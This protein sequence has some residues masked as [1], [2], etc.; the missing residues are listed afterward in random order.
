MNVYVESNFVLEVAL[1]QEQC[2]SCLELIDLSEAG[3]IRLVVPAYCLVEPFETLIRHE[4]SRFK[5]RGEV[6]TEL[7][8]IARSTPYAGRVEEFLGLRAFLT[9]IA[10][11]ETTRLDAT[12]S[13]LVNCADVIRLDENVVL[14]QFNHEQSMNCLHRIHSS[15]TRYFNTYPDQLFAEAYS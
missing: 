6:D 1:V 14:T 13:R 11:E 15:I 10:H 2:D 12:I 9:D 5:L 3:R 4:K 8:Q 7:S